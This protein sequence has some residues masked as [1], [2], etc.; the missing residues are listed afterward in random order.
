MR[1]TVPLAFAIAL[2]AACS[3]SAR[4]PESKPSAPTVDSRVSPDRSLFSEVRVFMTWDETTR[5]V[6]REVAGREF[7]DDD[8]LQRAIGAAHDALIAE[9][10][11]PDAP[12][13]IFADARIPWNQVMDVVN[14]VKRCGI[15]KIEFANAAPPKT[16]PPK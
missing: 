7:A 12:V 14:V 9:S 13:T 1:R 8:E 11:H 10:H 6:R 4:E 15:T 3:D 5:T 2:L 16:T